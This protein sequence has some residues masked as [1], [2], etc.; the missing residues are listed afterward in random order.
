MKRFGS[1]DSLG[2]FLYPQEESMQMIMD[3]LEDEESMEEIGHVSG[4][5]RRLTVEQ[6]Q[7]LEKIFEVD[8][9]L[10]PERKIKLAQELGLQPRQVAIWF[11]NRRARWKTK[12]LERDYN[13]LKADYENLQHSF[14]K[15]E[16]EKQTLV[17]ELNGL[18]EKLGGQ[19]ESDQDTFDSLIF[20]GISG[21]PKTMTN[22]SEINE[23][24]ELKDGS[25]EDSDN[26]SNG[27]LKMQNN[28]CPKMLSDLSCSE[29]NP[30]M[31][32]PSSMYYPQFL[33][34]KPLPSAHHH[35]HNH[36]HYQQQQHNSKMEGLSVFGAEE[37]CNIFS[38]EQSQNSLYWYFPDQRI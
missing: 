18:K 7:S 15:V 26:S 17:A 29:N 20:P 19:R 22:S 30:N 5:K 25:S 11:Q 36:N 35:N 8:N 21:K 24:P 33:D 10:D 14:S 3:G 9:K 16:Q 38:V 13:H 37:S 4:K 1:T 31:C 2:P 34:S 12:Q 28:L 27:F 6:V 32:L 23:V